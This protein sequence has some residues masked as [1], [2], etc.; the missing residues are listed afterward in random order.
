MASVLSNPPAL[1]RGRDDASPAVRP[2]SR[3]AGPSIGQRL[4]GHAALMLLLVAALV[5]AGV[6]GAGPVRMAVLGGA[7][8]L[9]GAVATALLARSLTVP[10]LHAVHVARQVAAGDLTGRIDP[11]AAAS[12]RE[13][14]E[15]L[16]GMTDSL[17][18]M[19]LNVRASADAI[20]AATA[21]IAAGNRA[22]AERTT[23]QAASLEETAASIEELT[24]TVRQNAENAQYANRLAADAAG[25]AGRG[26]A[27]VGQ[28]VAMMER[29]TASSRK[30]TDITGVIESIAFQTN[31][32]SL[33]AAVEAARAG[34]QGRGFAVVANE[35][36]ELASRSAD[37][38]K[39]IKELIEE[40]AT[41][42]EEG[43]R[44]VRDAG[45]TIEE[46]V[47]S[48][49]KVSAAIEEIS[50]AS[51]EQSAGI[52]QVNRAI[53]QMQGA[54]QEHAA[55]VESAAAEAAA[56]DEQAEHLSAAIKAFRLEANDA[57]AA[58]QALV[59][60]AVQY[61]RQHGRERAFAAFNDERGE[62]VQ[63]DLYVLVYDLNGRNL[64]HGANA[65]MR[66]RDQIDTRDADGKY[67]VRERVELARERPSF[68]QDYKFWN[69]VTRQIE[70]K[71]S[72]FERVDDLLVGCGFYKA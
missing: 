48:V 29:I 52:E 59:K 11:K 9:I 21:N 18:R 31:I 15:A 14:F 7:A 51:D 6:A 36:R 12:L 19:A 33:N 64:A 25:I 63:G 70:L 58:A 61:L 24:S 45:A 44:L 68:W 22:A 50:R 39:E 26:G 65:E 69:P 53:V 62:F 60:R 57:A 16:R 2:A 56:L 66:G 55:Q 43:G 32:L 72:Y 30:I 34:E 42:V 40:A 10:L 13:L 54:T 41:N 3:R 5:V 17:Q 47:A 35:V 8:L 49:N 27:A 1:A 67:F 20:R 37:A 28:V 4:W 71:S 46:V 38:A 23:A